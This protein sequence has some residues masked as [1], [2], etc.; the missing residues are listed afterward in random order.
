MNWKFWDRK[1]ETRQAQSYSDAALQLLQSMV[2]GTDLQGTSKT[3]V[4][5][6]CAGLWA[7]AFAS[8]EVT[9]ATPATAALTPA[10]LAQIGR[11][12]FDCGESVFEIE[13]RQGAVVLTP[14]DS[15]DVEGTSTDPLSWTYRL[16][17]SAPSAQITRRRGADAV[18]HL[19]YGVS[20]KPWQS[21]GPLQKSKTTRQL[22][23]NVEKRL[24][25]ETGGPVGNLISVPDVSGTQ[26]L[27][28]DISALRGKGILVP[29][30]AGAWDQGSNSAPRQDWLPQRLGA[31]PPAV[32]PIL[33]QGVGDHMAAAAGVPGA[34]LSSQVD[35]TGRREGWRQFLH[36]L[37]VPVSEIVL[38][39]LRLKLETPDLK[40]SFDSLFA[41]DV[42][43]RAR[44]LGSLVQAGVDLDHALQVTGFGE[45][46]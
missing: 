41:S 34:L 13:I 6:A 24:A 8:A 17:L 11:N 38:E 23:A 26:G 10:V 21:E 37:V 46:A 5:E 4:E 20:T 39:E 42:Q 18:V 32:M 25:D 2:E 7:R 30:T 27:Q 29:S 43:G 9:P 45:A 44:S 16:V 28:A 40:L 36:S 3:G 14:A 12:L 33:R 31:N 15:W 22:N 1:L 19:R 35:G